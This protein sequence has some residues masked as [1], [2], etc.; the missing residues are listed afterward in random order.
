M[1]QKQDEEQVERLKLQKELKHKNRAIIEKVE[2][3]RK[4]RL[5][6]NMNKFISTEKEEEIKI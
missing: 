3:E 5:R 4:R 1:C 6:R 2:I